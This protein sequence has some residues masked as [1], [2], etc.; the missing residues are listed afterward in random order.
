[1]RATFQN[2]LLIVSGFL[3]LF[4]VIFGLLTHWFLKK[5]LSPL[6]DIA[7]FASNIETSKDLMQRQSVPLSNIYEVKNIGLALNKMLKEIDL[8]F[9][10]ERIFFSDTAHTIKTPLSVLRAEIEKQITDN[11]G[12]QLAR[13][14]SGIGFKPTIR[15]IFAIIFFSYSLKYI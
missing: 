13:K 14:D 6:E 3:I 15:N 5:N 8:I 1:M 11:L 9:N 10:N 2:Y 12:E 4:L 7:E